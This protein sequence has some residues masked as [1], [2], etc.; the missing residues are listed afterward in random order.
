[1]FKI[2]GNSNLNYATDSKSR[3][4]ITGTKVYLHDAL[5]VFSSVM[6]KHVTLSVT[7]AE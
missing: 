7:E 3:R 5:I 6:Q 1:M 4:I 2:C